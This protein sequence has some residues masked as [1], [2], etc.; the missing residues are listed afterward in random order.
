[1]ES[2]IKSHKLGLK[3]K[4]KDGDENGVFCLLIYSQHNSNLAK[5]SVCG[6]IEL[7]VEIEHMKRIH[8]FTDELNLLDSQ[9][10]QFSLQ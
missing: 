8:I 10:G 6:L 3:V 4:S 9:T 7:I 5:R 2:Q 1:M